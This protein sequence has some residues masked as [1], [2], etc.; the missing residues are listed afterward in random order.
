MHTIIMVLV[1]VNSCFRTPDLKKNDLKSR[2]SEYQIII[3]VTDNWFINQVN[4]FVR[5]HPASRIRWTVPR[6][7]SQLF[8]GRSE[9]LKKINNVLRKRRGGIKRLIPRRLNPWIDM[10]GSERAIIVVYGM[11]GIGKSELCL[12]VAQK[13]RNEYDLE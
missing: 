11:G 1:R 13:M 6:Q 7:S 2:V 5:P 3:M 9:V 10:R 8:T 12:K 4:N